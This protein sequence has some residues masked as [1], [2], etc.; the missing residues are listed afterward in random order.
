MLKSPF[1]EVNEVVRHA[2]DFVLVPVFDEDNPGHIHP[3]KRN[4]GGIDV[5]Q[6]VFV[7]SKSPLTRRYLFHVF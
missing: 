5:P 3:E 6:L 2:M 4:T 1:F 7:L